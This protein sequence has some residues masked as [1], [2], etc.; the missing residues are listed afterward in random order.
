[1]IDDFDGD[2]VG[3]G[4]GD[5]CDDSDEDGVNDAF[6][7]CP[8]DATT[9]IMTSNPMVMTMALAMPVI[10]VPMSAIQAR[11]IPTATVAVMH[12]TRAITPGMLMRMVSTMTSIIV[13]QSPTGLTKTINSIVMVMVLKMPAMFAQMSVTLTKRISMETWLEMPAT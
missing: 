6:D 9:M 11:S 7:N 12:V 8:G 5:V 2:G 3:D 10:I 4:I 1:M 13:H